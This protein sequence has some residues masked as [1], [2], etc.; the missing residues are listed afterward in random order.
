MKSALEGDMVLDTGVLVEIVSGTRLG[1]KIAALLKEESRKARKG[2]EAELRK[3]PFNA[4][5][6]FAED[7][8]GR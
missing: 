5:L 2:L 1:R 3:E 6:V 8:L 4:T 7:L